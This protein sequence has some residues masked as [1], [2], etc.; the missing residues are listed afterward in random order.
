[1]HLSSHLLSAVCK[2]THSSPQTTSLEVEGGK[3]KQY[4]FNR[5]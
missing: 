2:V 3:A 5:S 4:Y 1:M